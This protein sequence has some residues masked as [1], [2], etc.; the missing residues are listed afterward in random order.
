MRL[1]FLFLFLLS[2]LDASPNPSRCNAS[3]YWVLDTSD[4][5]YVPDHEYVLHVTYPE[6]VDDACIGSNRYDY[7]FNTYLGWFCDG[8]PDLSPEECSANRYRY[9][10]LYYVYYSA[11]SCP[12][13]TAPDEN[14]ICVPSTCP[15]N[16]HYD[17]SQEECV[18]NTGTV[19]DGTIN[20]QLVCLNTP[21]PSVYQSLPLFAI[22]E[23]FEDCNFFPLADGAALKKADGQVCCYGQP[24][25]EHNNTCGVNEIE[26]N[27]VCYKIKK[28]PDENQ[29]DPEECPA[30]Q[31]WSITENSCQP[32]FPE[33][34]GTGGGSGDGDSSGGGDGGGDSNDTGSGTGGGSGDGAA[35][36]MTQ[37]AYK[38]G[39][40]Q[41]G[42]KLTNLAKNALDGYVLINLPVS[43]SGQCNSELRK[44]FNILGHT[45]VVD[46]SFQ[47]AQIDSYSS[48][49]YQI[50]LFI[51]AI[52]GVVA[53]LAGK[54]D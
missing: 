10:G 43:V 28:D 20:G 9:R 48:V 31:Y 4:P 37:D 35:G 5:D 38:S 42:D 54:G 50:V 52:S 22:E 30:G 18:C 26:I 47:F 2:F 6:Y 13:G 27:G 17:I 45:Y 21:C 41:Y 7:A 14:N 12:T 19:P 34:N 40:Q 36:A 51:F 16:S 49:I 44:T 53:V 39:L 1:L 46:L 23:S 8:Y 24:D 32:F 15:T 25:I 33:N 11:D 3:A 29:T